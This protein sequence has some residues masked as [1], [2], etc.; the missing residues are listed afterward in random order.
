MLMDFLTYSVNVSASNSY[1]LPF[2][3]VDYYSNNDLFLDENI[4]QGILNTIYNNNSTGYSN[5]DLDSFFMYCT[6]CNYNSNTD[7]YDVNVIICSG[8]YFDDTSSI[9]SI[10]SSNAVYHQ[11]S[12]YTCC[13]HRFSIVSGVYTYGGFSRYRS[14]NTFYI[15]GS[16]NIEEH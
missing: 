15:F 16:H 14:G 2:N 4:V 7:T 8:G 13:N 9:G 5:I 3:I 6:E 1:L 12:D 11:T 10:Y